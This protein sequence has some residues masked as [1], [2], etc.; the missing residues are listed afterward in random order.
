MATDRDHSRRG[1]DHHTRARVD[2]DGR[3]GDAGFWMV[4]DR[5][6][7]VAEANLWQICSRFKKESKQILEVCTC[8]FSNLLSFAIE[9]NTNPG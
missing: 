9:L 2:G 7:I 3:G 1:G 4:R 6:E 5:E 8:A